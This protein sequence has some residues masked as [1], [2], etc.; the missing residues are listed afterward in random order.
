MVPIVGYENQLKEPIHLKHIA[1]YLG[2]LEAHHQQLS[3][4]FASLLLNPHPQ[5]WG[6]SLVFQK[7]HTKINWLMHKSNK[8]HSMPLE[9]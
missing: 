9:D 3:L 2:M 8:I 7:I 1:K 6:Q 4:L 5:I